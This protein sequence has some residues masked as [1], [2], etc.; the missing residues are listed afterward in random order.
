MILKRFSGALFVL[1]SGLSCAAYAQ[2]VRFETNA[3]NF[4]MEL[5]PTHEP[6]L[7]GSVN[8]LLQYVMSGRYDNTV[9]NRAVPYFVL[10]M[11]Q[12]QAPG[13][14]PSATASGF[15]QIAEFPPVSG[16]PAANFPTL[17]NTS[18]TVGF[19]LRG[20]RGG[21]GTDRNSATSTFY[22]NLLD[23]SFLDP[24]FTIFAEIPNMVT[25]N[26]IMALQRVDLTLDPNFGTTS[27]NL[28]FTDVPLLANG[29]LVVISRAFVLGVP[30]PSAMVLTCGL[31]P[32][33]LT[34]RRA[35]Y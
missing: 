7:Q 17:S 19:A 5:N 9:I 20:N 24:D 32:G 4:D 15:V 14:K 29:D 23:N 13:T 33:L 6:L 27:N 22:I 11:G 35:R 26:A 10:Q 30:E 3:G 21:G 16:Q 12:F 31:L 2:T 28:A 25:I 1:I 8:N 18:G 34:R